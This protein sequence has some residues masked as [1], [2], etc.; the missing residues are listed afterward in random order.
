MISPSNDDAILAAPGN[1]QLA[2]GHEAQIACAKIRAL[3]GAQKSLESL[4]CGFRVFPITGCHAPTFD[5]DFTHVARLTSYFAARDQQS[6][7]S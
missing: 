7:A 3:T 5:P 2:L 1:K 4:A 6:R